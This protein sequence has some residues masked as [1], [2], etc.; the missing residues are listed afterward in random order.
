MRILLLAALVFGMAA[1]APAAEILLKNGD[2]LRGQIT[3]Q[4]KSQ[5]TLSIDGIKRVISKR[6][7]LRIRDLD[8]FEEFFPA[9]LAQGQFPSWRVIAHDLQAEDWVRTFEPI[10]PTLIKEGIFRNVP[11]RSFL[12]NKEYELNIY[13]NPNSP[14]AIEM[15]IYGMHNRNKKAQRRCKQFLASYLTEIS[16]FRAMREIDPK[17]DKIKAGGLTLVVTPPMAI[18]AF[19][20]WWISIYNEKEVEKARLSDA[21]MAR[22]NYNET[23]VVPMARASE[24]LRSATEIV[25]SPAQDSESVVH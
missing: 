24:L 22:L 9:I 3:K 7:I 1:W 6:D 5:V 20:A 19:G 21:Q 2:S 10:R 12:V 17:G 18:D 25:T 23:H 14:A 16:Q 4:T 8:N 13:G 15:G 11:Y